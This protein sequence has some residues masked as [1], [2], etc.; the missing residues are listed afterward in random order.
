[1]DIRHTQAAKEKRNTITYV[2]RV[3]VISQ[4]RIDF[5]TLQHVSAYCTITQQKYF[6]FTAN[7][8][9]IY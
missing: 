5:T 1:M 2:D 6:L 3:M 8:C 7:T 4:T 9:N